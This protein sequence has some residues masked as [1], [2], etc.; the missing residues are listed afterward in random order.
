MYAQLSGAAPL[1][2]AWLER[3]QVTTVQVRDG[4]QVR[5]QPFSGARQ[6]PL[7]SLWK[8]FVYVHAIDRKLAT[9]DYTCT[10]QQPQEE[11]YCCERGGSIGRDAALAQSCGLFFAPARLQV[12]GRP[13]RQ[14]WTERLGSAPAGDM[15]WLA[16][17]GQLTP[18]RLVSIDSLLRS[19]ASIP[20]ASR[21]EAESAL[22]RVALGARG[23][24][25]VGATGS[26]LRVK[27]YSWHDPVRP[28]VRLGGAAGWLADGTP[29]W[30]GSEGS[31]QAVLQRWA[32]RLASVLPA[33][34]LQRDAGCVMVDYF[35]RYPLRSVSAAGSPAKPGILHGGH[36]VRFDNGSS[37]KLVSHGELLLEQDSRGRP[38][39]TGHLGLNEYVARVIDR[40]GGAGEPEAAK[41]LAIAART[42]LQQ[43]ARFADG[44]QR[45]ADSS[46]TQRVSPNRATLAARAIADWTDQLVLSGVDV[47]YHAD[48]P[49]RNTMAWSVAVRQAQGGKRF[50]D[51]LAHA[52]PQAELTTLSGGGQQCVR[53]T[54]A[55]S[56]LARELPRWERVLHTQPGYE[57]PAE[58]PSICRLAAGMPYSEQSRNRIFVRGLGT[59]EERITLAHEYLHLGLRNH[60]RGHDE[61]YVEQL[62]RRLMDA[63]LDTY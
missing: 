29:V 26:R 27:T 3:G 23:V 12:R 15:A 57:R 38:K 56:W 39:L 13:W 8:L 34:P 30:F 2:V 21:A 10:G 11:V 19:L 33:A 18:G 36:V 5:Q 45:I 59:R 14:Y 42:Y 6:V 25:T 20:Q 48:T 17:P 54:R 37:L 51:I 46:A 47:F 16:D 53:L 35:A 62:A 58:P 61:A 60:P 40:E 50:D 4:G 9:P 55:Q 43:N 44:C 49:A 24:N 31:S 63:P 52:Y 28:K 1:D 41:A 32:P 22:L 7:G